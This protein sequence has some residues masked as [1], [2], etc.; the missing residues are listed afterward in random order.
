MKEKIFEK[1][2]EA[3]KKYEDIK[4]DLIFEAEVMYANNP[5]LEKSISEMMLNLE[6]ENINEELSKRMFELGHIKSQDS[7]KK[8]MQEINEL[9]KKKEDIKNGRLK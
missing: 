4:E 7:G 8:I 1:L 9:N 5:N 2:R 3:Y 6:E